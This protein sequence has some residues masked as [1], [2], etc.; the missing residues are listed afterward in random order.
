MVILAPKDAGPGLLHEL[1]IN[2]EPKNGVDM[3]PYGNE[4]YF[5][6]RT[7]AM[8]IPTLLVDGEESANLAVNVD[9]TIY[10]NL[11]NLGNTPDGGATILVQFDNIPIGVSANL[12]LDG[13]TSLPVN[14]SLIHI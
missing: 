7:A 6:V 9:H 2:I 8:K 1:T 3:T 5:T 14:L 11:S 4:Y 12:I 13:G 10:G